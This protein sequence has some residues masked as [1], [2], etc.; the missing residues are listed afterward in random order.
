LSGTA[1]LNPG[2]YCGG[3]EI[4]YGANVTFNPGTYILTSATNASGTSYGLTANIGALATGNGITFYNTV[5]S[6]KTAG[7]IQFNYSSF[8]AGNGIN[9]TAPATGTYEGILFFQDS[10]NT[11]QA[12]IIGSSSF[13]TVLQGAYYFP[14]AK[15]VFALDGPIKYNILDAY[16]IEFAA[17]T[18]AGSNFNT[19]GFFNDYSSLANG[20]PVKGTG[21]V[22]VE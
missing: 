1:T 5:T 22:L 21:G 20:S 7:P 3:I 14:K 10:A 8:A 2:V 6:G 17:L 19:S 9:F 15:V 4:N 12:Q 18:F 16:Q 13:N 11:T